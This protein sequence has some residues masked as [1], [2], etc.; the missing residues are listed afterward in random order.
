MESVSFYISLFQPCTL[1][2]VKDKSEVWQLQSHLVLHQV[3]LK[4]NVTHQK[5]KVW[6]NSAFSSSTTTIMVCKPAKHF[7]LSFAQ[8]S[9][10]SYAIRETCKQEKTGYRKNPAV[11]GCFK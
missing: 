1:R 2:L 3:S 6:Y 4:P 5:S 8:K 9:A 10:Q 7:F 11:D